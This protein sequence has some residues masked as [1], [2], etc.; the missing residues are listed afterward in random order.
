MKKVVCLILAGL[1]ALLVLGSAMA[2]KDVN[3]PQSGYKVIVP[4]EMSYSGPGKAPDTADFAWVSEKLG[5]EI[6]FFHAENRR[7]VTLEAMATVL[8]EEGFDAEIRNVAGIDMIVYEG[9]DPEDDPATAMKY[10]TYVF[11][12]GSMAQQVSFWYANQAA[13]DLTAQIIE[14]ITNKD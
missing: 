1:L 13:A 8:R 3:L 14:S 11:L 5:L 9:T 10:I 6:D 7:G 2:E 4:D 12:E